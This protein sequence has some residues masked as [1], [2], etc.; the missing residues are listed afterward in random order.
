MPEVVTVQMNETFFLNSIVSKNI[1][2]NTNKNKYY[3]FFFK[4]NYFQYKS[5]NI[6]IL[7]LVNKGI[8]KKFHSFK[9]SE[10]QAHLNYKMRI[11]G[12]KSHPL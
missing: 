1:V 9:R 11:P 4:L 12:R 10:H 6:L 8:N 5:T 7:F 2:L 3:N